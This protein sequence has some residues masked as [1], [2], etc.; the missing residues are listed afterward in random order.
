[1]S[2]NRRNKIVA[3]RRRREDEGE[4]EGSVAADNEDDSLSEGSIISNGD[5]DADIEPS[6]ISEDEIA[7]AHQTEPGATQLSPRLPA[8]HNFMESNN[9]TTDSKFVASSD[10]KAM[11]NGLKRAEGEDVTEVQFDEVIGNSADSAAEDSKPEARI[12]RETPAE[13]SRREHLEY[14]KQKKENPAFVPTRGGFFLHD[15]RASPSGLNGFGVP[16]RGRGRGAF[17]GFQTRYVLS[18]GPV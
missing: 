11:M 12:S 1:M 10:T 17:N 16:I 2:S 15:D 8:G 6:D 14:L 13:R 7:K 9:H 4:E 3:S 5:D 18:F